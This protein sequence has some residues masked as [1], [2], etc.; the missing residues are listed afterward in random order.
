MEILGFC[1]FTQLR[2]YPI[3]ILSCA[4]SSGVAMLVFASAAAEAGVV[5]AD[6]GARVFAEHGIEV[7][8]ATLFAHEA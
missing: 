8:P 6:V 7:I 2:T 4:G 1:L 3:S 5:A